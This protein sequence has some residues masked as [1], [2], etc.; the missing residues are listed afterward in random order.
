MAALRRA[1]GV[2]RMGHTGTLD[3]FA[4]GL[5]VILVGRATRLAPF[6][7]G[8][9]KAY[10]GVITL[11]TTT[12]TDDPT[13]TVTGTSAI[14]QDLTRDDVENAMSGF[15][16]PRQQRPPA[17]S[18]KKLGGQRAYRLARRGEDTNIPMQDVEVSSFTLTDLRGE[19]VT[20]ESLVSSGT[21]IRSLARDLGERLG[22]GAHLSQLRRT[23]VGP[24]SIDDALPV[25]EVRAEQ[26][27]PPLHAVAHLHAVPVGF[28]ERESVRHGRAIATSG[29]VVGHV[30]LVDG[31]ELIAIA[32][33]DGDR[34]QPRVVLAQ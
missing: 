12:N 33:A 29:D 27:R 7:V 4:S 22:C 30:A 31:D 5:L 28:D 34:L 26:V 2:R 6:L 23:A 3:P 25:D 14:W 15:L 20:F 10:R 32:E 8:L 19:N 1:L 16:G 18:A 17:F 13:G 11:G 9:T 21:Y 24:F